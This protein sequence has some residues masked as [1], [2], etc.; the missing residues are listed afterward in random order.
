MKIDRL[1][2]ILTLLMQ[3]DRVTAPELAA[4]F[5]VSRRTI[6]RDI[7][8]LCKAK[9]PVVTEQGYRGGISLAE[10]Y[11]L[12][13]AVMSED[14]MLAVVAGLKGMDSVSEESYA[15][16]IK[17]K[18]TAAGRQIRAEDDCVIIDLASYYQ[19]PLTEKI[20]KLRS[21]VRDLKQVTFEY[22]YDKGECERTIEPYKLIFKWSSWY[23][24]GYCK[25]REDF[26]MFKL[27]RLWNI[28]EGRRF[29][30]R[31]IDEKLLSFGEYQNDEGFRLKA[32]F[33]C[34]VKHRLID[35]YGF[36]CFEHMEDGRLLFEQNF[37]SYSNMLCWVLGFGDKVTVVEPDKLRIDIAVQAQRMLDMYVKTK[38]E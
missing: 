37:V 7:E 32:V 28:R 12:D 35:E 4:M 13:K 15:D 19:R 25:D 26:R 30:P 18:L 36:G 38:E 2:G 29:E 17:D 33:D 11:R 3:R 5:E 31:F 8:D 16:R 14:E 22:Y 10:G 6:N 9:I 24:F 23:V 34:S 1:M 21:A 20:G 27:N